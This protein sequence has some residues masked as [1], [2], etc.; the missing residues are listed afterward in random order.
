MAAPLTQLTSTLKVFKWTPE[1][2][3]AFDELKI[4]FVSAPILRH[5]NSAAQLIVEVDAL[6]SGVGAVLSQRSTTD[7]K[8][9]AK[10]KLMAV[11]AI[12]A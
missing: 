9:W 11:V 3:A 6:D 1:A 4:R 12:V 8:I 10:E 7:N 5:L 2:Y